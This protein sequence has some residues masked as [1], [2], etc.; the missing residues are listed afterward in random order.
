MSYSL[1]RLLITMLLNAAVTV[2]VAVRWHNLWLTL[3][4]AIAFAVLLQWPLDYLWRCQFAIVPD[5]CGV[6]GMVVRDGK[7]CCLACARLYDS[8]RGLK[9]P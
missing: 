7:P 1:R 2:G 5:A 9:N 8:I 3:L 4:V 6:R